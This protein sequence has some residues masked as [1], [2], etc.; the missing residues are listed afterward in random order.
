MIMSENS[1]VICR[2]NLMT[3][4]K[5]KK[6]V[7]TVKLTSAFDDIADLKSPKDATAGMLA[8]QLPLV[9]WICTYA[10]ESTDDFVF[11]RLHLC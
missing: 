9:P 1:F 5:Q 11:W 4:K 6:R 2:T 8:T 7:L 10:S 3:Q